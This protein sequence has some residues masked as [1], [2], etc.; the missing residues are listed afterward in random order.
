MVG[1]PASNGHLAL[2]DS[3]AVEVEGLELHY[4]SKSALRDIRFHAPER[5]VTTLIGPS[6]CGKSSF[7]RCLNRMNDRIPGARVS[8][9]VRIGGIDPYEKGADLMRLR[10]KVG[11]VFQKPNPFPM[12]IF[13][14]VAL[15]PRMHFGLRGRQLEESVEESLRKAALWDEVQDDLHKKNGLELSGGQ[16][17]RLCIARMLAVQPEVILMDEPCSALDPINSAKIESLAVDLAKEHTVLV[18]THNLQQSQRISH[19][20]AFFM[21]GELVES[22]ASSQVLASPRHPSTRDYLAG[23][24]G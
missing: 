11:M 1:A 12:S 5:R 7:L 2:A 21:F 3:Y 16:Q 18:V 14:N 20:T 8:G 17:Q 9:K 24:F 23:L 15:A 22:G 10:R 19:H 13:D 6:G 4:G